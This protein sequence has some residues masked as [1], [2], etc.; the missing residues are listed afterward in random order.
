MYQ[1]ASI[2]P[3]ELAKVKVRHQSEILELTG[4]K[5]D[6]LR[7]YDI[8]SKETKGFT[9]ENAK[10]QEADA[11]FVELFKLNGITLK[12]PG[13]DQAIRIR[14]QERARALQLLELELELEL[15]LG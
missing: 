6:P 10:V 8:L 5:F 11:L 3:K 15:E 9:E 13:K 12:K 4:S 7:A 14:E 1:I 2:T